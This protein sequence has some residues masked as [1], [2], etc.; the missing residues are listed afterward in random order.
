MHLAEDERIKMLSRYYFGGKLL[1][2][3]EDGIISMN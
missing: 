2:G 1:G 3:V